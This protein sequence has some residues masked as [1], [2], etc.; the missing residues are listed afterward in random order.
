[1]EQADL[2]HEFTRS[3]DG[4]ELF[5]FCTHPFHRFDVPFKHNI[6]VLSR[7]TFM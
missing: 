5:F 7:I 2:P 3:P 4:K 1:M 6:E